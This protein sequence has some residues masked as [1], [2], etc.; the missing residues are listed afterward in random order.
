MRILATI[1]LLSVFAVL[2]AQ[3]QIGSTPSSDE[4]VQ[5]ALDQEGWNYEVD[6]DGD[7]KMVVSFNGTDRSQLVYVIS[8]TSSIRDMEIREVWSPVY[9]TDGTVPDEV[10]RWAAE[11]LWQLKLGSLAMA[12]NGTVYL[13][14]KID[15]NAP[16]AVLSDVIRVSASSADDLEQEQSTADDL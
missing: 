8:R 16:P 11:R 12:P 9:K 13:V 14:A 1:L 7:F 3:A 10:M 4:L 15:S 6:G 2:P 5:K